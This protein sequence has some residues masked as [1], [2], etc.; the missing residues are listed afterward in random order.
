[1][2]DIKQLF[3]NSSHETRHQLRIELDKTYLF[4]S[5]KRFSSIT[6]PSVQSVI[7][8]SPST[9]FLSN[10]Q[11]EHTPATNNRIKKHFTFKS[12]LFTN[13][14]PRAVKMETNNLSEFRRKLIHPWIA[15]IGK[16]CN[17]NHANIIGLHLE[18]SL[19]VGA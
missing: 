7:E 12:V 9:C 2:T 18:T 1:M 19:C 17:C 11:S 13:A 4:P 14:S 6:H 10:Y 16:V 15:E 8:I 5:P 3:Y